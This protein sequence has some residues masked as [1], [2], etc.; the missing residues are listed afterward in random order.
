M[1]DK[2]AAPDQGGAPANAN[3]APARSDD[4]FRLLCRRYSR[5]RARMPR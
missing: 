1:S 5:L 3:E 4:E 2:P